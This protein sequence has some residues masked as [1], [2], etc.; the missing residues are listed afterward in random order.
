MIEMAID[1]FATRV[2]AAAANRGRVVLEG[3]AR[4]ARRPADVYGRARLHSRILQVARVLAEVDRR[5]DARNA[6]GRLAAL[7]ALF[8]TAGSGV[9]RDDVI[10]ACSELARELPDA[11]K[12][13]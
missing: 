4:D 12:G 10:L 8:V 13:V 7:A 11:V 5:T 6:G 9:N 3:L 1:E 2:E